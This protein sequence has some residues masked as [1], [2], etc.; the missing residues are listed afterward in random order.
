MCTHFINAR[1]S[2]QHEHWTWTWTWNNWTT[3]H[4]LCFHKIFWIW[5]LFPFI[6]YPLSVHLNCLIFSCCFSFRFDGCFSVCLPLNP[7]EVVLC[8]NIKRFKGVCV[9]VLGL[10]KTTLSLW[11]SPKWFAGFTVS[12]MLHTAYCILQ[13][14]H[15]NEPNTC[16]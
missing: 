11:L 15:F 10:N 6:F 8:R 12:D 7:F 13:M 4:I 9:G 14:M 1:W 3:V 5:M 2:I 16:A